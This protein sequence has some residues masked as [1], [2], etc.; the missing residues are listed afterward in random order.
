MDKKRQTGYYWIL[1]DFDIGWEIALWNGRWWSLFADT[2]HWQDN[3]FI[4]IDEHPITRQ[5]HETLCRSEFTK[6]DGSKLP[7]LKNLTNPK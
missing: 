1:Q 2:N 7:E 6:I 5:A 4:E 3:N